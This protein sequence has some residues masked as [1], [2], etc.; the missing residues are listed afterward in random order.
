[1]GRKPVEAKMEDGKVKVIITLEVSREHLV[2]DPLDAFWTLK[3]ECLRQFLKVAEDHI[4]EE[5]RDPPHVVLRTKRRKLKTMNGQV[6]FSYRVLAPKG[7]PTKTVAPLL[8]RL[9]I[10]YGQSCSP[11]L[12]RTIEELS[13]R[14]STREVSFILKL[15]GISLSHT[16]VH[17]KRT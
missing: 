15:F 3:E 1:M 10:T 2:Q 14:F 11:K 16:M 17:R 5:Y 13:M 8:E 12:S 4:L 9:N 7:R 6:E